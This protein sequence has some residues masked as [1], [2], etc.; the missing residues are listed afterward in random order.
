MTPD[1]VSRVLPIVRRTER[2]GAGSLR[3]ANGETRITSG[4]QRRGLATHG[5]KF[6]GVRK[7]RGENFTLVSPPRRKAAIFMNL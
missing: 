5:E 4:T 6:I 7:F 1:G 2:R 3:R